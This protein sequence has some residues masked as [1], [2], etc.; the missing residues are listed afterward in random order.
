MT[1]YRVTCIHQETG[2][3][4]QVELECS[5]PQEAQVEALMQLY[6]QWG[7]RHVLANRA[8]ETREDVA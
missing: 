7:W 2:E 8:E 3:Q 5:C 6:R 1:L 4:A